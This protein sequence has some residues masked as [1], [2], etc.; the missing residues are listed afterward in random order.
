MKSHITHHLLITAVFASLSL[1]TAQ[2]LATESAVADIRV[3]ETVRVPALNAGHSAN[4]AA[5]KK[6]EL[7]S[8]SG[9]T[10]EQLRTTQSVDYWFYDAWV[11]L[12]NDRDYDGYF[13]AFD[14]EFD[15]D[16]N[17]YRAPVYAIVYLG[18]ADYYEPFHVTDVFDLYGDSSE[19]GVLLENELI[20]GYPSNDYDILIEL[21]DADTDLHVATL[22]AYSDADLSYQSIESSDYDR[23]VTSEVVI[24]HHGGSWGIGA[25]VALLLMVFIRRKKALPVST[26]IN[27]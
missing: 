6:V 26:N 18:T 5:R 23:P 9:K 3:T 11:T 16:T 15:A 27:K 22:D 19:D 10:G 14:L 20:T 7:A 8:L 13:S 21:I 12:Y 17:Y 1:L 4:K 2:T 24:E 25:S